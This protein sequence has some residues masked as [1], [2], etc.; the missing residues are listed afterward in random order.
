[1]KKRLFFIAL[2]YFLYLSAFPEVINCKVYLHFS[3]TQ[4]YKFS[5]I[6]NSNQFF[7]IDTIRAK[8][9][10]ILICIDEPQIA[11]LY[12]NNDAEHLFNF[13]FESGIYDMNI[14]AESKSV[15]IIGSLLN[16]EY[17]EK[18]RV[19]DSLYKKYNIM[20]AILYP[21]NHMDRD[22]AHELLKKYLPLCDSLSDIHIRNFYETHPKSFLTL[23]NI[24]NE[25]SYTFEDPGYDTILY[26]KEKLR[27]RFDKLGSDLKKYK[28]YNDCLE[29]FNKEYPKLSE[30]AKSLF[31]IEEH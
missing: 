29:L 3:N 4:N 1:M 16:E 20:H 10:S 22:S 14:D 26:N 2:T 25:L 9:D 11:S 6:N 19:S 5:Y 28:M 12:I 21:Y 18:M 24:Y 30:P 8:E 7:F 23:E 15:K 13:Y 31:Q 27:Q 17:K